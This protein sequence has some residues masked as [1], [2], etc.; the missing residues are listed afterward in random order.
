MPVLID[1]DP[2][3]RVGSNKARKVTH[4][5]YY[6]VIMVG[7]S[8]HR[9]LVSR[10]HILKMNCVPSMKAIIVHNVGPFQLVLNMDYFSYFLKVGQVPNCLR[11]LPET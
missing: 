11:R 5:R 7:N 6:A 4:R 9:T 3:Q 2:C 8:I 1:K 10:Y